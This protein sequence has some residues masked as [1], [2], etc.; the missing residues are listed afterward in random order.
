MIEDKLP[1][2][3]KVSRIWKERHGRATK[4]DRIL[5]LAGPKARRLP[6][7]PKINWAL[8]GNTEV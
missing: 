8:E 2:D 5:I 7:L 3:H 1:T 6:Q 4:T